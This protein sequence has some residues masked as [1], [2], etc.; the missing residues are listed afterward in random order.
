MDEHK[1]YYWLGKTKNSKMY[2]PYCPAL[3]I[4]KKCNHSVGFKACDGTH[5][6]KIE[7][8]HNLIK[9]S[10]KSMSELPKSKLP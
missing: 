5:A 2:Q 8:Q 10:C 4:H 3:C 7:G 6:N 9:H 1:A